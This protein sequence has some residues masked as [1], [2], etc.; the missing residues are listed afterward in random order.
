MVAGDAAAIQVKIRAEAHTHT[1]PGLTLRVGDLG[2]SA[3]AGVA[4]ANG[5]GRGVQTPGVREGDD[6]KIP[7]GNKAVAVEAEVDA[8]LVDRKGAGQLNVIRQVVRALPRDLLQVLF[9][10][11]RHPHGADGMGVTCA[12]LVAAFGVHM[13]QTVVEPHI[14]FPPQGV[15]FGL[16]AED[17]AFGVAAVGAIGDVDIFA[18]GDVIGSGHAD[19]A[20][21]VQPV[22]VDVEVHVAIQ[23]DVF[24]LAICILVAGDGHAAGDAN[25]VCI[26]IH[27]AAVFGGVVGDAA[28]LHVKFS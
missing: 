25:S 19:F 6:V 21:R 5:E 17:A 16:V 3:A 28:A 12:G 10:A 2:V 4:V 9:R 11:D 27:T 20:V 23:I 14:C 22:R 1:A 7:L 8:E 13:G 18:G 15:I 26:H 24:I